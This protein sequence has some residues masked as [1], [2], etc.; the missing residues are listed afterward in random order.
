MDAFNLWVAFATCLLR[1]F[2]ACKG[3]VLAGVNRDKADTLNFFAANL[4]RAALCSPAS[5]EM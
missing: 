4:Y 5:E 3:L 1:E 2:Q